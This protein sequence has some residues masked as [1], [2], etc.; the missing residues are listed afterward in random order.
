MRHLLVTVSLT[1]FLTA[2]SLLV[3]APLLLSPL[4]LPQACLLALVLVDTLSVCSQ[5]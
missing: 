1:H 2:Q 5:W 3:Q 4:H